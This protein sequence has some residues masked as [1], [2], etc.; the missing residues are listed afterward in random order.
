MI[1]RNFLTSA[2]LGLAGAG[3]AGRAS[4]NAAPETKRVDETLEVAR[5]HL[6]RRTVDIKF[7]RISYVDRGT[8]PAALFI[9]GFPLNGFQWR[10]AVDRL[11]DVRRC[12]VPDMLGMGFTEP[13]EGQSLAPDAQVEMLV[14]LMDRLGI[15]KADV[16]A[17]D[18][19]GAVAQLF[20]AHAPHRIR[21]LL[22]TNGDTEFDNPPP[23]LAEPIR[24]A[25][26]GAF[27]EKWL[28]AW[29][30]DK[31]L[32]R[33]KELSGGYSRPG[34]P[35]DAALETYLGPLVA[36]PERK[37]LTDAFALALE[38]NVLRAAHDRLRAFR[39]PVRIL[40]G[41]ADTLFSKESPAFLDQ[42]FP[43]SQGVRIIEGVRFFFPEEY[44][45]LVAEEA[46]RLWGV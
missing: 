26:A 6:A 25:H 31:D 10:G 39:G 8:G 38:P 2:A 32:A 5:F 33:S 24:L 43:N 46:R 36:S 27:A 15:M 40:W 44:P 7:G 29:F 18:S 30:V 37:A 22:L 45:E 41:G 34:Y 1:R 14:A 13:K 20:A 21:S 11:A 23:A 28:A 9:H 17:N 3:I 19:G 35:S 4:A 12:I 42:L 16:V